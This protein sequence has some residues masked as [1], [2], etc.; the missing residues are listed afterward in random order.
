MPGNQ[1]MNLHTPTPPPPIANHA[2]SPVAITPLAATASTFED[3]DE[4]EEMEDDD[5]ELDLSKG[6]DE[7]LN[8]DNNKS[9]SESDTFEEIAAPTPIQHMTASPMN[10]PMTPTLPS[11]P[12]IPLNLALPTTPTAASALSPS[13]SSTNAAAAAAAKKR[14]FK[15]ASAP[16]RHPGFA[17][18]VT[19]ASP[20]VS[21]PTQMRTGGK[22]P[23]TNHDSSS[24]GSEEDSSSGSESGSTET[25]SSSGES[26][27]ESGSDSDEDDDDFES[28]AQDISMSLS[29]DGPSAPASPQY[30]AATPSTSS[31][32]SYK[33][34]PYAM[35]PGHTP[36][37]STTATRQP[38]PIQQNGGAGPMSLRALFSKLFFLRS[39][40]LYD[41]S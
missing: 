24:S 34:S 41:M 38:P 5:F 9:D 15:M 32:S 21:T 22:R 10:F 40:R 13:S 27:S 4:D 29:K 37:P 6:I 1:Y 31:P 3:D 33:R 14:K 18:P 25:G 20:V 28:L 7:I 36:T 35:T 8:S 12:N 19:S 2:V 16:I 26:G 39:H 23:K 11:S 30:H 17:S